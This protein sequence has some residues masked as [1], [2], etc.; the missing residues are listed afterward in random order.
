MFIFWD[1]REDNMTKAR[2]VRINHDYF[3]LSSRWDNIKYFLSQG[4]LFPHLLD[5]VKWHYFP[6]YFI[7]PSFPTHLEVEASSACQMRCPMCKTTQ[8]IKDGIIFQGKI[9]FALYKKIIDDCANQPLYSIK[10]SWR[11]EPLL[12]PEIIEMIGYAKK[13]GIKDVAFLTNGERLH[14]QL[15]EKLVDSGLDWISISVDGMGEVYNNIRTPAIFEETFEKI[16]YMRSYRKGKKKPLIRVQSVHSAIRGNELNFLKTWEGVADR[17]NFIADQKRSLNHK[18][19]KHDPA[20]V[21]PSPWQRMCIAWDG[22]VVQCYS[23]YTEGNILG[24][25]QKQ[26]I[27]EIWLGEPFRELRTLMKTGKRLKTKPCRTCSDGG[28]TEDEEVHL[29]DRKIKAVHYRD[30]SV[31]VNDMVSALKK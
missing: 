10:L 29:G 23:D 6:K 11:G 21:C 1:R 24:D 3:S 18:D 14:P 27:K 22:K 30:Q 7:V 8:M 15:T 20:Y 19:Y 9:K 26:S 16:K 4:S 13:A 28:V 2:K 25:V 12:N 31:N 5:R 17:V